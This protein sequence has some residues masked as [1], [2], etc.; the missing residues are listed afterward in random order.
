MPVKKLL[1]SSSH[2]FTVYL[3]MHTVDTLW[4]LTAG[5]S[6]LWIFC[7]A[8]TYARNVCNIFWPDLA[9]LHRLPLTWWP[10]QLPTGQC[11]TGHDDLHDDGLTDVSTMLG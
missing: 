9:A 6:A 2:R 4:L 10:P 1:S 7:H 5:L 11:V 8:W 3:H